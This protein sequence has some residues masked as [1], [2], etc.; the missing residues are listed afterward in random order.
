MTNHASQAAESPSGHSVHA[1]RDWMPVVEHERAIER[2]QRRAE[3][4]EADNRL[5]RERFGT[6]RLGGFPLWSFGR[7]DQQADDQTVSPRKSEAENVRLR[8]KLDKQTSSIDT[9]KEGQ[10]QAKAR[11]SEL[12]KKNAKLERQVTEVQARVSELEEKNSYLKRQVE[13]GQIDHEMEIQQHAHYIKKLEHKI[14]T[15][16]EQ[17]AA[18]DVVNAA[19]QRIANA[20][21]VS[22]DAILAIWNQMAYNIRSIV[23]S[24]LTQCPSEE[25]VLGVMKRV[26]GP[27]S[28]L[29]KTDFTLFQNDDMRS[30]MLER[31][32]WL[33]VSG[34]IRGGRCARSPDVWGGFAGT[35]FQL[36]FR[37]LLGAPEADA[38]QLLRWKAE[39]S[40]MIEKTIG[41]DKK[42]LSDLV[43][44]Q[45]RIFSIFMSQDKQK[46]PSTL[47]ELREDI[48][49][50]FDQAVQLRSIFMS[51]RAHFMVRWADRPKNESLLYR[52]ELMDAEAWEVELDEK[53]VV[54]FSISPSLLKYGTANGA[55]YD[56]SKL[57][58]KHRVVCK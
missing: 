22:D 33:S 43:K 13:K 40:G 15:L 11:V 42:A 9:Y 32:I 58:V 12:E 25:E 51:S 56:K 27:F 10:D 41:V 29:T 30:S 23:A 20:S 31:Y 1:S 46:D 45:T 4:S 18:R 24:L 26:S 14:K 16:K 7:S 34:V 55:D 44:E 19:S 36:A 8:Q 5:L 49:K 48:G 6:T 21:K 57:L 52:A 53:T 50:V 2:E 17:V 47:E 54:H 39:G 35:H 37:A 3:P 28:N 38:E